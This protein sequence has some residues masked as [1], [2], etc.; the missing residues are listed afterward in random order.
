MSDCISRKAPA[1]SAEGVSVARGFARQMDSICLGGFVPFS[2]S[3]YPSQ[4][5]AVL[6]CQGCPWRCRYCHNPHLQ[7]KADSG[8]ID[9]GE[10]LKF[11]DSRQGLLD[12]VVFS[13][14]EPTYQSGLRLAIEQVRSLSFKIGLHTAGTDLSR[15]KEVLPLLDWVGL[16]I[17]TGRLN[18]PQLTGVAG[19]GSNPYA[20]LEL[21]VDSDL[22][23]EVRTTFHP[24]LMGRSQLLEICNDL[25][26]M[27]VRNYSLQYFRKTGCQ[28][29]ELLEM[30]EELDQDLLEEIGSRFKSF[31]Y[32]SN[33][34]RD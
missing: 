30:Y 16:D 14:G 12:A 24:L 7:Q 5:S 8:A 32:R 28:D 11:L 20:A 33:S 29:Q 6:F 3:D 2:T 13:G 27:G 15:F 26:G 34:C 17:K 31:I 22:D 23:Y 9:F 4:L 21:L 25:S 10:V 1:N 18:Y 19:S